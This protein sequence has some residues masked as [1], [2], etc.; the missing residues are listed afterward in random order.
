MPDES[1]GFQ[2]KGSPG[3]GTSQ[4]SSVPDIIICTDDEHRIAEGNVLELDE[5]GRARDD[6]KQ[7]TESSDV[8]IPQGRHSANRTDVTLN[9]SNPTMGSQSGLGASQESVRVSVATTAQAP[10]PLQA[11]EMGV[12][13][14]CS[15]QTNKRS[16]L[17]YKSTESNLHASTSVSS[18]E[19]RSEDSESNTVTRNSPDDD[20]GKCKRDAES[21]SGSSTE[22]PD[23]SA[24]TRSSIEEVRWLQ[25]EDGDGRSGRSRRSV[26][27]GLCC[28]YQAVHRAFLQCVEETPAMVS[29]L[30]LS[31]AFCVAL[32]IVIPTTR[33]VRS[34]VCEGVCPDAQQI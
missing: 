14:A 18:P 25:E 30:V 15:S 22:S 10:E 6:I 1:Q 19:A 28:C 12:T 16:N 23:V 11:R 34:C 21:V 3:E 7:T 32:I 26:K 24:Q 17:N 5:F 2:A 31:M 9:G 20:R 27:E 29:G 33:G 4:M 8:N 13:Q